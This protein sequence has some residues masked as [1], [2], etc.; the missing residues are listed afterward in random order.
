MG[1][2]G[3]MSQK[4]DV[5][6]FGVILLELLTGREP[7]DATRPVGLQVLVDELL[8]ILRGGNIEILQVEP[9]HSQ[10]LARLGCASAD[11]HNDAEWLR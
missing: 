6:A 7:V 8:P 1:S 3:R 5:Y 2:A 11:V 9:L 10:I 4:S